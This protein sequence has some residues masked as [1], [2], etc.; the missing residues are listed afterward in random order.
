VGKQ[1][2]RQHR[3]KSLTCAKQGK[4]EKSV[5]ASFLIRAERSEPKRVAVVR[6]V[7]G[8]RATW[9]LVRVATD[10]VTRSLP[11]TV[12]ARSFVT[13]KKFMCASRTKGKDK[14]AQSVKA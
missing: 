2:A 3:L 11:G 4:R 10:K 7:L 1:Y 14:K 8:A 5:K 9:S 12:P 6:S 13:A